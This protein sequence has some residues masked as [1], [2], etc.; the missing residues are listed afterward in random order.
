VLAL[1]VWAQLDEQEFFNRVNSNYYALELTELKN[2]SSWVTSNVFE[3][4]TNKLY[5]KEVYP[6]ELIWVNPNSTYFIRRPIQPLEDSTANVNVRK[7]Q[8]DLQEELRGLLMNW[9]RFYA[10]RL[11]ANM[12]ADFVLES[13]SDT[14]LLKFISEEGPQISETIMLFGQNGLILKMMTTDQDSSQTI[15]IY[16]EYNY[17]GEY[18]LCKGWRVQILNIDQV[19]SGFH[20]KIISKRINK[21]WLP[22]QFQMTLQSKNV[23]DKLFLRVYN[24]KNVLINRDIQILNR[25]N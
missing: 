10:G 19:T 8:S 11:L 24:F 2:F 1:N 20:V 4:I 21:Y 9:S 12:P 13:K 18:W 15:E 5:E 6:L 17:T 3:E 22:S 7:A 16:P 25:G 23:K 14:V